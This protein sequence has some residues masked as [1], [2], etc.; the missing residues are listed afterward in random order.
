[1]KNPLEVKVATQVVIQHDMELPI[2]DYK[3]HGLVRIDPHE[4]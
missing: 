3:I 1:M 2:R 4:F